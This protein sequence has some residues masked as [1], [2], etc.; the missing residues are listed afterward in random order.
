[1]G[2]PNNMKPKTANKIISNIKFGQTRIAARGYT[3][4]EITLTVDDLLKKFIQQD[5][6][7]YWSKIPLD[8]KYNYISK[9]PLAISVDRLDNTIG[10]CYDN[11]ALT[12]RVFNLGKG[13]YKGDFPEVI[14]HLKEQWV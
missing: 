14:N 10:Y 13:S 6:K 1:M 7:C 5:G 8:D 3:P 2:A 11:V 4:K 12:L 9:H